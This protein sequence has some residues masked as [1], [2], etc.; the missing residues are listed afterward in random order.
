MLH[1][2]ISRKK[3][4]FENYCSLIKKLFPIKF[5][6]G[7]LQFGLCMFLTSSSQSLL[8]DYYLNIFQRLIELIGYSSALPEDPAVINTRFL[9]NTR[10]I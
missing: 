4:S 9:L 2:C 8:T 3:N 1:Y 6:S 7:R 5:Y 10:L